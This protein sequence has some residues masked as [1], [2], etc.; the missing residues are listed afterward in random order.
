MGLKLAF[1]AVAV[2]SLLLFAGCAEPV[3]PEATPT[4]TPEPTPEPTAELK[5]RM[6]PCGCDCLREDELIECAIEP[7]DCEELYG[8]TDESCES[9]DGE[10]QYKAGFSKTPLKKEPELPLKLV[11]ELDMGMMEGKEQEKTM[12]TYY[13]DKAEACNG[14]DAILGIA[15]WFSPGMEDR[16]YAK[17]TVYLEDGSV[18]MSNWTSRNELA[19]DTAEPY[20]IDFEFA[21][22]MNYIFNSAGKNFNESP[23]WDGELTILKD[24]EMSG[25]Q[26]Q[27]IA[28]NKKG[29]SS[30]F[31]VPCTVFELLVREGG[32]EGPIE[33]CVAGRESGILL[34]YLVSFGGE[35]DQ[36]NLKA[37]EAKKE[38][39]DITY[40]PQCLEPVQCPEVDSPTDAERNACNAGGGD[41]HSMRDKSNCITEWGCYT[42][43][44]NAIK[45]ISNWG[46][47]ACREEEPGEALI[48]AVLKCWKEDKP[49][50]YIQDEIGC[51]TEV[52]CK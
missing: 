13:F 20:N 21:F 42:Q 10:C 14:M 23:A 43:R 44:D 17:F 6:G 32:P 28:I 46:P 24:V 9:V 25:N 8:L 45:E 34:P 41:Y 37:V 38:A 36:M 47:D 30:D 50:K 15:E 48:E 26:P 7:L 1:L 40:Y 4:P 35:G 29:D 11:Y 16:G 39:T 5:C 49:V 3:G 31:E 22:M 18:G 19:F 2:S 52:L 33:V 27:D 12:L 51:V